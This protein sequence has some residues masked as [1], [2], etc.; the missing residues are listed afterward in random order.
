MSHHRAG[1]CTN[2]ITF[3]LYCKDP[4]TVDGVRACSECRRQDI[5][6]DITQPRSKP[7]SIPPVRRQRSTRLQQ[8]SAASPASVT[9]ESYT[10]RQTR[11]NTTDHGIPTD[12][13]AREVLIASQQSAPSPDLSEE[14]EQLMSGEL[15]LLIDIDLGTK[16]ASASFT[17][18]K[19]K[20][21]IK[22]GVPIRIRS[23]LFDGT[24]EAPMEA[25]VR[26]ID[27][28]LLVGKKV[29]ALL[30]AN[31]V[32]PEQVFRLPKLALLKGR[33]EKVLGRR[34][35]GNGE[36]VQAHA[37]ACKI[38]QYHDTA[39]KFVEGQNVQVPLQ[40]QGAQYP[41]TLRSAVDILE[42]VAAWLWG[43]IRHDIST[44]LAVSSEVLATILSRAR[45]G[46]A[47]PEI[48]SDEMLDEL[49]DILIKVGMPNVTILSEAKCS[50]VVIVYDKWCRLVSSPSYSDQSAA[51][52]LKTIMIV[53]DI[54]AGT[55]DTT[56][57][58]IVEIEPTLIIKTLVPSAG[59]FHGSQ[60]LNEIFKKMI[61]VFIGLQE[62]P[63]VLAQVCP[64]QGDED[65]FLEAFARGFEEA[66][67]DFDPDS[68]S[69]I[70]IAFD[71]QGAWQLPPIHGVPA[72]QHGQ[73]MI[74][75][76]DMRSIFGEYVQGLCTPIYD[77][78][79][80]LEDAQKKTAE[81]TVEIHCVGGG[82]KSEF[83]WRTL[84]RK[85]PGARIKRRTNI[86]KNS[87]VAEGGVLSLLGLTT[88]RE[89]VRT[90]IGAVYYTDFDS[91][92]HGVRQ[93]KKHRL[94]ATPQEPFHQIGNRVYWCLRVG[95]EIT[96]Q[97]FVPHEV[98]IYESDEPRDKNASI[99]LELDLVKTQDD[100]L[101]ADDN[102]E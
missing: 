32:P 39:L 4:T 63:R 59:S 42:G 65:R 92:K 27:N 77:Q 49:L 93:L 61:S 72:L 86:Q 17:I 53:F 10:S 83:I 37:H 45:L 24:H 46:V 13:N 95:N 31:I 5:F 6:C 18:A 56:T 91:V 62:Y 48:W 75:A 26:P 89:F 38:R 99:T 68:Q 35:P 43:R 90:A 14:V 102:I 21:G 22:P 9:P 58:A 12:A 25:V 96:F 15:E 74:S 36:S 85:F 57:V 2:C 97:E 78:L 55:V 20:T 29:Q 81:T 101:S 87:M 67:R 1:P 82:S 54:G 52:A 73:L 80:A 50:A 94:N 79:Q 19:S 100:R 51:G 69:D 41:L 76:D 64:L 30:R 60:Q 33:E 47:A 16:F 88:E 28:I 84:D 8:K 23:V 66:K 11:A 40:Y 3:G 98:V 71:A 44:D 34:N 7:N 70:P